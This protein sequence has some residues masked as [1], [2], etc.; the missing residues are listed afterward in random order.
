MTDVSIHLS[1]I[2]LKLNPVMS[3]GGHTFLCAVEEG[4]VLGGVSH[5]ND[6]GSSQELHDEAGGDDGGDAQLHQGS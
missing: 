3:R 5:L 2:Y 1:I 4:S 6:L